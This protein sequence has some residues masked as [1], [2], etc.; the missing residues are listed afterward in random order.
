MSKQPVIT[1]FF[2]NVSTKKRKN[3]EQLE[4]KNKKKKTELWVDQYNPNKSNDV[5][6]NYG[7]IKELNIFFLNWKEKKPKRKFVVVT[8]NSGIGKTSSVTTIAKEHGFKVIDVNGSDERKKEDLNRI[9]EICS[10]DQNDLIVMIIEEV[11]GMK[12]TIPKFSKIIKLSKIPIVFI[13]NESGENEYMRAIIAYTKNN[14]EGLYMEFKI[15]STNEVIKRIGPICEKEGV[16][17][18]NDM[19]QKFCFNMRGDIRS[20][21]NNLQFYRN[22]CLIPKTN[23][24]ISQVEKWLSKKSSKKTVL[25]GKDTSNKHEEIK[26]LLKRKNI[27]ECLIDVHNKDIK[28]IIKYT[29][30]FKPSVEKTYC[31]VIVNI[32][33]MIIG[34]IEGVVNTLVNNLVLSK[35]PVIILSN[36]ELSPFIAHVISKEK[37]LKK[38][39]CM[40]IY[41]IK[42]DIMDV[43]K[44]VFQSNIFHSLNDLLQSNG[45][46]LYS[47]YTL[48]QQFDDHLISGFLFENYCGSVD[49]SGINQSYEL[50]L[51]DCCKIAE[52]LSFAYGDQINSDL[53]SIFNY[54]SIKTIQ[55]G[56]KQKCWF[57]KYPQEYKDTLRKSAVQNMH[58]QELFVNTQPYLNKIKNLDEAYKEYVD[59]IP[60]KITQSIHDYTAFLVYHKI[61]QV[62]NEIVKPLMDHPTS[63][64]EDELESLKGEEYIGKKK[65]KELEK[66]E[67]KQR[68]VEKVNTSTKKLKEMYIS[69][70]VVK[71]IFKSDHMDYIGHLVLTLYLNKKDEFI[72]DGNID[73]S[74]INNFMNSIGL[75]WKSVKKD[76]SLHTIDP[77]K[78]KIEMINEYSKLG[79]KKMDSLEYLL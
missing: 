28:S 7:I 17:V 42:S 10:V 38:N 46:M 77:D 71:D 55:T 39:G 58:V 14:K 12:L 48:N 74:K 13:S 40:E 32:D 33:S 36:N 9:H 50:E 47:K 25:V 69:W 43:S 53:L 2:K 54:S 21:L 6:G 20:I 51:D 44:D 26:E 73:V 60:S 15:P 70:N 59:T 35:Y 75:E 64:R 30:T 76:I 62:C 23:K 8:G 68:W 4:E 27:D 49:K 5:V 22:Q 11:D 34:N 52:E 24:Y 67:L 31:F 16:S 29:N 3:E 45:N 72:E 1:N 19:L 66:M 57:L 79:K 41:R 18:N 65:T 63:L 56:K 37:E 61:F 78:M